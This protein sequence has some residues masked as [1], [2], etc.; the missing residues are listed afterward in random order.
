ML[1]W[2]TYDYSLQNFSDDFC[3]GLG[4]PDKTSSGAQSCFKKKNI[5]ISTCYSLLISL[6]IWLRELPMYWFISILVLGCYKACFKIHTNIKRIVLTSILAMPL[7]V[8]YD[9]RMYQMF[10]ML[11]FENSQLHVYLVFIISPVFF[12]LFI[13]FIR[14]NLCPCSIKESMDGGP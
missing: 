12:V 4:Y 7:W 14:T 6:C 13:N 11:K 9:A 3:V 8:L 2:H 5:Y 1:Q 10:T